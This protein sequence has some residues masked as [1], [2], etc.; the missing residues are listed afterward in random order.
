MTS[1]ERA[2]D[3][4]TKEGM[5]ANTIPQV[6]E[7]DDSFTHSLGCVKVREFHS[8]Y[9]KESATMFEELTMFF[10]N[11][12]DAHVFKDTESCILVIS[13]EG[14]T[15][16]PALNDDFK[17]GPYRFKCILSADKYVVGYIHTPTL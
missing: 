13:T 5:I 12:P 14:M 4:V 8:P 11:D 1:K 10:G 2:G 17:I 6:S 3:L 15:E 9:F 7:E 16:V